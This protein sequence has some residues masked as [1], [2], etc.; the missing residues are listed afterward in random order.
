M[1]D[2]AV[3]CEQ[4]ALHGDP[5]EFLQVNRRVQDLKARAAHNETLKNTMDLF[6]G[7]SRRFWVA[8]SGRFPDSLSTAAHL[9][10]RILRAIATSDSGTAVAA[11]HELLDFL[12]NFTKKTVEL[13][14]SY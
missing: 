9:H 5:A 6:Y 10:A 3:A 2:L 4:S 12:E 7:L 8:Y 1:L 11:S 13:R 14:S